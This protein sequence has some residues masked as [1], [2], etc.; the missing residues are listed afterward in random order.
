MKTHGTFSGGK[1][2]TPL[3]MAWANMLQRCY[4]PR[5]REWKNYGGRGIKV[6]ERWRKFEN[7]SADIGPHPGK[8]WSLDRWPN[9]NG[10]YEPDNWRWAT[11]AM[12]CRN[13]RTTK[14]SQLTVD[15][16]RSKYIPGRG[17]GLE[18]LAQEYGV[19]HATIWKVLNQVA[20]L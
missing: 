2:A 9:T 17:H 10:N 1:S 18:K 4:N 12:Q 14:L 13:M 7:F 8:G 5:R 19:A 15:E 6:C 3:Y 16:I 20:W 11:P